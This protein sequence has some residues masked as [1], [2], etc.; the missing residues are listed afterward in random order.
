M[1]DRAD[2]N[3][4]E[5]SVLAGQR[6]RNNFEQAAF[7]HALARCRIERIAVANENA[8]LVDDALHPRLGHRYA[9]MP[10]EKWVVVTDRRLGRALGLSPAPSVSRTTPGGAP[11]LS[12]RWPR[13][14]SNTSFAENVCVLAAMSIVS[15]RILSFSSSLRALARSKTNTTIATPIATKIK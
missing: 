10:L 9:G 3:D 11:R 5:R 15:R 1:L 12:T 13:T 6:Q 4:A 7:G 14:R 8:F 2:R